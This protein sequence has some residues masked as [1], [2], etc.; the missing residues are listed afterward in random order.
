MPESPTVPEKHPV[1][2]SN[3]SVERYLG[4]LSRLRSFVSVGGRYVAYTSDVGEAFRPVVP[5]QIVT[6]AYVISAGYVCS[7]V[8]HHVYEAHQRGQDWIRTAL[9]RTSFQVL[10]S[11]ALPAIAI[12]S[13]VHN[14]GK[15]IHH[16]KLIKSLPYLR[17]APT[18][19]GLAVLPLLPIFLDEPVETAVD[20]AF[21]AAWPVDN[22]TQNVKSSEQ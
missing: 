6:A 2:E 22:E 17:Y 21:D 19:A 13:V 4:Y 18:I 7:D 5:R 16:S 14:T 3:S 12:H 20:F 15:L 8:G 10:A 1:D 11:L 9:H